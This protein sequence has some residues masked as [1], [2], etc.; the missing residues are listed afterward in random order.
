MTRIETWLDLQCHQ[1]Q[2]DEGACAAVVKLE[3]P[4]GE[5]VN[6]WPIDHPALADSIE[7]AKRIQEEELPKGSHSYRLVSYASDGRQMS[8]LPQTLRGKGELGNGADPLVQHRA[9]A[10]ALTNFE[11]VIAQ[12]RQSAEEDRKLASDRLQDLN[13]LTERFLEMQ[14]ANFESQLKLLEFER[15]EKRKDL[16][17][18]NLAPVASTILQ[19]VVEKY[20]PQINAIAGALIEAAAPKTP[21]APTPPAPTEEQVVLTVPVPAQ[22]EP[23][24]AQATHEQ[25]SHGPSSG[26]AVRQEGSGQGVGQAGSKGNH[27]ADARKP[28]NTTPVR[29]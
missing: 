29:A 5:Q 27:R 25:S 19:R 9:T 3:R 17:Y 4:G 22:Q 15:A 20:Q 16:L 10:A 24:H 8:E 21:P 28:R 2:S 13:L 1:Y 11:N 23:T 26:S 7:T 14:T 12:L 18:E 6:E